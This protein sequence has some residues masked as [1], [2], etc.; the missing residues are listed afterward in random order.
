[1]LD[2]EDDDAVTPHRRGKKTTEH[3][4][5][6]DMGICTS[7]SVTIPPSWNSSSAGT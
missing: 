3:G 7:T 1:M 2:E 5:P 4:I 6:S